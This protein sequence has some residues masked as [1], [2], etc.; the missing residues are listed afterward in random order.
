MKE[1]KI[2]AES[3]STGTM[4]FVVQIDARR[5]IEALMAETVVVI[6]LTLSSVETFEAAT[7]VVT[8]RVFTAH[9][10]K[11]KFGNRTLVNV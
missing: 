1:R 3:R 5:S 11:A 8:G 2:T 9:R 6:V 10:I 7:G 4:V